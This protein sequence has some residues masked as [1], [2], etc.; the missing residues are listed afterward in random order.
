MR[1]NSNRRAARS[2][3]ST[4]ARRGEVSRYWLW[5]KSFELAVAIFTVADRIPAELGLSLNAQMRAA[6][7]SVPARLSRSK[8]TSSPREFSRSLDAAIAALGEI[9]SQIALCRDLG[10][11]T[12]AEERRLRAQIAELKRSALRL[13]RRLR[14]FQMESRLQA[15]SDRIAAIISDARDEP[16]PGRS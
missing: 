16:G 5:E 15:V 12:E 4:N 2:E 14:A 11:A 6:A 7:L 10:Y 3:V 8:S 13:L 9:E 1:I